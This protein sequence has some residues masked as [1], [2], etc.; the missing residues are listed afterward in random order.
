MKT[1]LIERENNAVIDQ[2]FKKEFIILDGAMGTMLQQDSL[3]LGELPEF[4][5][6]TNPEL[7][8]GIHKAYI[9]AGADIIYANTFG[10][11]AHKLQGTVYSVAEVVT[12]G[13]ELAKQAAK[14]THTKVA[15]DIGPIGELLEPSGTLSF[16]DAYE[17]FKEIVIVGETAGADLIVFETM[18]DLYEVKAAVLAA[19]E[20]TELPILV[21]MTFEQDGRTFTGCGIENMAL[22]LEGLGVSAMGFNCSLGPIEI[23]PLMKKLVT[24]TDIPLIAKPNAGLPNTSTGMYHITAD[25]FGLVMQ[26]YAKLGVKFLG[27][28]CGTTEAYIRSLCT[29]INGMT[30]MKTPSNKVT[31]FCTAT[32]VVTMDTVRVI[33][34]RVNPTGKKRLATALLEGDI[35]YVLTQAIE[36]IDAGAEILD[37]NVGVP[38][39]DEKSMMTAIVKSIQS[40]VDTPL[41]IDSSHIGAL[42]AGLRVYNGK[43]ILN[44]VNGEEKNMDT[45]LPIAKKYGAAVIC[46]TIDE[47]GIPDSAEQRVKIAKKIYQR[48][49]YYGIPQEDILVDCLALTI[50][51]QQKDCFETLHAMR[52]LKEQLGVNLVLGVSNISFGLPNR[53]LI[54]QSFLTLA[55]NNGLTLP[56]LN[57]NTTSM[58][59]AVYA[60][61]TLS[62]Y[63]VDSVAY[64]S[65]YTNKVVET[66]KAAVSFTIEEAIIKGLADSVGF[67][68]HELLETKQ[69]LEIVNEMIVPA[70]DIVGEKY[71]TGEFFLPQ[72]I[73]SANCACKA[74]EIIKNYLANTN[75]ASISKGKI[76]LATVK[77]DIHDIGKNIVKVILENYGYQVIDLGKNVDPIVIVETAI[78][79]EIR[80]IGLSAL[81]TTTVA[82]MKDTIALL[83]QSGHRCKVVVGGAVLTAE[84]GK[85]IGADFYAK[86]AKETVDIAK[87]FFRDES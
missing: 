17:Y 60:Y 51:A 1:A 28:C 7:I 24:Y 19:K 61:R 42:E 72:L 74:F 15:I 44:S 43:P 37:V 83:K 40:V 30:C 21:T 16:E 45:I 57:P 59:D 22:T 81:M 34:E 65:H 85:K 38:N 80:L 2:L 87:E 8:V 32:K 56:I 14:G 31:R 54:N 75:Q 79:E 52:Q 69:P 11:N 10:A 46:L 78:Q 84:Y 20:N 49:L 6:F 71:E 25:T 36:Q 41:Q 26:E 82:S 23:L 33:G 3:I 48:A 77:G 53:E 4:L 12:A 63:D 18:I 47:N 39:L 67:L 86:D 5:N 66:A 13:V 62:G 76:L 64:I 68:V 55:M 35:P 50:S 29:H 9:A 58:M 27:G 73:K 70:L